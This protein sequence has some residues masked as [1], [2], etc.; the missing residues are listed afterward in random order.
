MM[1]LRQLDVAGGGEDLVGEVDLGLGALEADGGRVVGAGGF[2]GGVEGPEPHPRRLHR[3]PDLRRPLP[4][5]PL[6]HAAVARPS[7][8]P[9]LVLLRQR[10]RRRCC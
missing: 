1:A 3:V 8:R 4:P 10:R 9:L 5:R 2:L 6:P 7:D